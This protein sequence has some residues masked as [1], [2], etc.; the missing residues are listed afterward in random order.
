MWTFEG[1]KKWSRFNELASAV[2]AADSLSVVEWREIGSLLPSDWG[3]QI[4]EADHHDARK[5]VV[6][7]GAALER[8]LGFRA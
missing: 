2:W 3:Y 8:H 7:A 4:P 5:M 6:H 1:A